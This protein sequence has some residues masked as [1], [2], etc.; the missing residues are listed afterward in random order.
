[1]EGQPI[2]ST[3]EDAEGRRGKKRKEERGRKKRVE[4]N[5]ISGQAVDAAMK[6]HSALGPGLLESA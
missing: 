6:V 4:I 1:M 3:A 5:E 2:E